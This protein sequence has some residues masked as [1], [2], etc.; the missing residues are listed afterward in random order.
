MLWFG[1]VSS[2]SVLLIGC[3][4]QANVS[5]PEVRAAVEI[6][7]SFST[8]RSAKS[9][10]TL[11]TIAK[12]AFDKEFLLQSSLIEQPVAAMSHGLRSRVVAFRPSGSRVLLF[13]ATNGHSLTQ[14]LPQNL[15][16]AT[17][18]IEEQ[19]AETVSFDFNAGMRLI[20]LSRD[21]TAHDASGK[22][23]Q[24]D[25]QSADVRSSY[26]EE[27]RVVTP[28]QLLIRQVGQV[29]ISGLFGTSLAPIEARYL[30]SPYQ[31]TPGFTP[32][33]ASDFQRAG[34]FG[35]SP[36]LALD[37]RSHAYASKFD[38][39]KPIR[40]AISANTPEA[41]K[42]AVRD[43]I[44]Y[45]KSI[46]P[47]IEAIE[48]PA[49]SSA[50]DPL[51]NIIQWVNYDSAG[52]AYADAQMD[53]RTGEVLHAQAF[54]TSTFAFNSKN[55]VRKLLRRGGLPPQSHGSFSLAGFEQDRLCNLHTA[56]SSS[57]GLMELLASKADDAAV[58]RTSQDYVRAVVAHEVGHILGL[59]HNFAGS[60]SA[61]NFPAAKRHEH[62]ADYLAKDLV[63]PDVEVTSSVMDYLPFFDD[64]LFGHRIRTSKTP[65][66]DYDRIA[67]EM[68]YFGKDPRREEVPL[69]CT[70]TGM[71]QYL[72]CRQGDSGSSPIAFASA[73]AASLV[74][75]LPYLV[76]EKF[77]G[78][79]APAYWEERTPTA[80]VQLDV[81][82]FAKL[83]TNGSQSLLESYT[84][85]TR[86]LEMER[87]FPASAEL[88]R[89][90]MDTEELKSVEAQIQS[91]G[92]WEKFFSIPTAAEY[93]EFLTRTQTL[94]QNPAYLVGVNEGGQPFLFSKEDVDTILKSARNLTSKLPQAIGKADVDRLKKIPARWKVAGTAAGDALSTLIFQR[95]QHYLFTKSGAD[96]VS[97]EVEIPLTEAE[98]A[99]A[100]AAAE[101]LNPPVVG[102]ASLDSLEGVTLS[103][104]ARGPGAATTPLPTTKK[105]QLRLPTYF[106]P[107]E[108]RTGIIAALSKGDTSEGI[109]WGSEEKE[110]LAAEF[111]K[112]M[113]AACGG[114]KCSALD[115]KKL[116]FADSAV[117]RKVMRWLAEYA[118]LRISLL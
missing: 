18:P 102:E 118:S 8:S 45:W 44:L 91:I 53:P 81:D 3:A 39:S 90:E 111:E 114:V 70:D 2:L 72:D 62:F 96:F 34:F 22:N 14:D 4:Q 103:A 76:M 104:L 113:E 86:S 23:Y 49:G 63:A 50:P 92:G 43:G 117:R 32:S 24:P 25:F 59:R 67:V 79:A 48:A 77:I 99:A 9:G 47:Q 97:T 30:L 108:V 21:W 83:L 12:S 93:Q 98:I 57:D 80:S 100:K 87:L 84:E 68:L 105:I 38:I 95:A 41:Y 55:E 56:T 40:L 42:Q 15:L 52:S 19:T 5:K 17:F 78:A 58:L 107:K 28:N 27:V 29:S 51:L 82:F 1:F 46:L 106:Y 10:E 13:E 60:L 6:T 16:L 64:V 11:L 75:N 115:P 112:N 65:I 31:P 109:D 94:L 7:D 110:K 61:K 89:D 54:I 101:K 33:P 73:N 116:Q 74:S 85:R 20:L 69:F 36:K 26:L 66:A 37:G 35:V 88:F 71:R